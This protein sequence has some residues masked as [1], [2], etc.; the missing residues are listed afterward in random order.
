[1]WLLSLV[2][3]ARSARKSSS[4]CQTSVSGSSLTHS[5]LPWKPTTVWLKVKRKE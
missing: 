4:R 5:C 3:D 1:M 2:D